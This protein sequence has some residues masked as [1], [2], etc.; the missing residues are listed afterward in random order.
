[1]ALRR[2]WPSRNTGRSVC[3]RWAAALSAAVPP[4]PPLA[5]AAATPSIRPQPPAQPPLKR[6]YG[7]EDMNVVPPVA[8]R[9]SWAALAGVFAVRTGVVEIVIDETGAVVAETMTVS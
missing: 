2:V 9:E 7:A 5:A 3:S 6:I 1:M 4:P 8:V